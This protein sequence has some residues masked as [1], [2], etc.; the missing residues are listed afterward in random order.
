MLQHLLRTKMIVSF[1]E[2]QD[3]LVYCLCVCGVLGIRKTL[4]QGK[5]QIRKALNMSFD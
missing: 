3:V 1:S 2:I 4:S 5:K